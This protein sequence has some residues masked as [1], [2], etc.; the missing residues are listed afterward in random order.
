MPASPCLLYSSSSSRS[1]PS[2]PLYRSTNPI[3]YLGERSDDVR[4]GR[5]LNLEEGADLSTGSE[6]TH[7][8]R[9]KPRESCLV[10][11][12][13]GN[14]TKAILG[15]TRMHRNELLRL[16]EHRANTQVLSSHSLMYSRCLRFERARAHVPIIQ[17]VAV[18][19]TNCPRQNNKRRERLSCREQSHRAGFGFHRWLAEYNKKKTVFRRRP[20]GHRTRW[21]VR[22]PEGHADQN[23]AQQGPTIRPEHRTTHLR[24]GHE[25]RACCHEA[26]Y[27]R[28]R[29]LL[30]CFEFSSECVRYTKTTR[31]KRTNSQHQG[32][33]IRTIVL[34]IRNSGDVG[35]VPR[36]TH[37]TTRQQE[38]RASIQNCEL[39]GGPLTR[40]ASGSPS[41]KIAMRKYH[42]LTM[43]V[44]MV[45]ASRYACH[46][47]DHDADNENDG[48]NDNQ[49]E[50]RSAGA[51]TAAMASNSNGDGDTHP[52][53]GNG[54]RTA[55]T[56]NDE[57]SPSLLA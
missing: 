32:K 44:I 38:E 22:R 52:D 25:N 49:H 10:Q 1:F 24:I 30:L 29:Q 39:R 4:S 47:H 7:V 3:V 46:R 19:A 41:L 43:K 28:I 23:Q 15:Y 12:G 26:A 51:R 11:D 40:M 2:F 37:R 50:I 21:R 34:K 5:V 31:H 35:D 14:N 9:K 55:S 20:R 45:Q 27:D 42:M 13:T 17:Y 56:K 16:R 53:I 48:D 36:V 54:G 8:A 33:A 6:G 57:S 18:C